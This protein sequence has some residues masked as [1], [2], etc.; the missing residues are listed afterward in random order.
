MLKI[1]KVVI[2]SLILILH[3]NNIIKYKII[4]PNVI[5]YE[6]IYK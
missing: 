4:K 3:S 5:I 1:I 6:C 2:K